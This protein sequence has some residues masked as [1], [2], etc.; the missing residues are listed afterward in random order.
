MTS[1][2]LA[3]RRVLVSAHV[4]EVRAF[5]FRPS[6]VRVVPRA[7]IDGLLDQPVGDARGPGDV[8][9]QSARGSP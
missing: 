9:P 2:A 5:A 1:S 8:Q 6:S 3:M 7:H 4:H